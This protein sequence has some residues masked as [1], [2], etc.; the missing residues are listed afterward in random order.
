LALAALALVGIISSLRRLAVDDAFV[1]Y[2]YAANL[3]HGFGFVY[4]PGQPVLSTTAPFYGLL[5]S[6]PARLG[7]DLPLV[8]NVLGGLCIGAGAALLAAIAQHRG[9]RTIGWLAGALY[10]FSPLLWL[11]LGM[12]TALLL[13]LALAAFLADARDR[14]GWAGACLGLATVTRYDAALLALLLFAWRALRRRRPPWRLALAAFAVAAPVLVFLTLSF[15]SPLPVTL[16]AKRGQTAV[17]VTGFFAGTTYL[18]GLG[19]LMRG[20]LAQTPLYALGGPILLIGCLRALRSQRW[21][22]I[23]VAWAGLHTAAYQWLGV[24]PYF[25]YYAP[26][27]PA[28]ALLLALGGVELAETAGKL[29]PAL[30][31]PALVAVSALLLFPPVWSLVGIARGLHAPLPAPDTALSKVLPEAK[32]DA[33][34]R[35]GEWLAAETP[36]AATVGVSEVGVMGFI[37]GRPMVDFLGLIQP[38]AAAALARGDPAWTLHTYQPD[39]LALTAINPLYNLDPRRDAW[40]QAAYRPVQRFDDARF[41]GSPV[42]VYQR[43]TDF[44][45][46]PQA[47]P[48]SLPPFPVRFGDALTLLAA[49]PLAASLQPGQALAVRLWWRRHGPAPAEARVSVQLLGENDRIIAQRD[50]ALGRG[51]RPLSAWQPG[52]TVADLVLLGIP[53][54][55]CPPDLGLLN[56]AVYDPAGGERLAAVAA[57]G[58][59]LLGDSVRLGV[60]ELRPG[61]EGESVA[62]FAGGIKLRSFALTPRLVSPGRPVE[63]SLTW[64]LESAAMAGVSVFVHLIDE[65]TGNKAAQADGP[66]TARDRRLL[67]VPGDAPPG[68]YHPLVGLYRP[69]TGARLPVLDAVGQAMGDALALCPLR[70]Q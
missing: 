54:G 20:W 64:E 14:P 11:A 8:G 15:G 55:A 65:R 13:C 41:W 47:A 66:P 22:L 56:L 33:Y 19:I 63:L 5:L 16:A 62:A 17:G 9:Q 70:V 51:E 31:T 24:A 6:L 34:R 48:P 10:L 32:V 29:A 25:W 40:F 23:F 46:L 30:R 59:A 3:A 67:A 2:R 49:Q 36:A 44:E 12:E 7:L 21:A 57:D 43:Q 42:V 38:D 37:S 39:Y 4:N 53:G 35:V 69:D 27:L 18:G 26:L 45:P 58:S 1:T 68:L 61:E 60:F 50:A 28:T 52:E